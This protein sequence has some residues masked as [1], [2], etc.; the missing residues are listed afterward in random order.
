MKKAKITET[1][2]EPTIHDKY[3]KYILQVQENY[4][5]GL[6]Y[7]EAMEMLRWCEDKIGRSIGLNMSCS[8]CMIDL[9]KMFK[10][11]E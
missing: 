8:S 6:T 4:I 11:L 10:N 3:R 2:T 5:N 7:S 9:I 1:N